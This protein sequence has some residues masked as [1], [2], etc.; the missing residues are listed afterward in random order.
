V[1]SNESSRQEI[2]QEIE[3]LTAELDEKI[4][5]L[6][7]A[8]ER[9][10]A[11]ES[12]MEELKTNLVTATSKAK[13]LESNLQVVSRQLQTLKESTILK[14]DAFETIQHLEDDKARL[15]SE[16]DAI[17][18]QYDQLVS[19]GESRQATFKHQE[20]A[21]AKAQKELQNL[22]KR[23]RVLRKKLQSSGISASVDPSSE[24]QEPP[25]VSCASCADLQD[26]IVALQRK[27]GQL[28]SAT[29]EDHG[30]LET[31]V[32]AFSARLTEIGSALDNP[33]IAQE[34]EELRVLLAR[35]DEVFSTKVS[36]ILRFA[37]LLIE[38][39]IL[40][41][42]KGPG[43]NAEGKLL[44]ATITQLERKLEDLQSENSKKTEELNRV[45]TELSASYKTQERYESELA[46]MTRSVT[47]LKTRTAPVPSSEEAPS[48][49]GT[50]SRSSI[51]AER[52]ARANALSG[53]LALLDLLCK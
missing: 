7:S 41:L 22:T 32:T 36:V 13:D 43:E 16:L 5:A 4:S 34:M 26:K 1:N 28:S 23:N 39:I 24:P 8:T 27:I 47:S 40:S 21:L 35:D 10:K 30:S 11:N 29:Q 48:R 17:R 3:R 52:Q 53:S 20:E 18:S 14:S 19:E 44:R 49:V 33:A 38:N 46:S 37:L 50:E 2:H 25:P 42:K 12:E 9:I 45:Q 31:V 15:V 6:G 51:R